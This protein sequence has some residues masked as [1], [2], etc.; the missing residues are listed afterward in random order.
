VNP[1]PEQVAF[2][3]KLWRKFVAGYQVVL[4]TAPETFSDYCTKFRERWIA[5]K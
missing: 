2:R 5:G 4:I 1:T 3:A